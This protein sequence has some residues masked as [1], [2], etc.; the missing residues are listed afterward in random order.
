M[1][2]WAFW[3]QLPGPSSFLNRVVENVQDGCNLV[4]EWP[5]H[6]P[7]G[8]Q[9]GLQSHDKSWAGDRVRCEFQA[10]E[11][12]GCHP[13]EFLY[14]RIF[15]K[16]VSLPKITSQSLAGLESFQGRVI[17]L[18][19]M[20]AKTW[21]LWRPFLERYA[22]AATSVEAWRRTLFL[23]SL[24][25]K[26]CLKTPRKSVLLK[27]HR[28]DGYITPLDMQM[29][30]AYLIRNRTFRNLERKLMYAL[31]AR[32]SGWDPTLLDALADSSVSELCSPETLL[33]TFAARRGWNSGVSDNR[34]EAW[35]RGM[36][37]RFD[38]EDV[39]HGC[40]LDESRAENSVEYRLWHA[41]TEVLLPVVERERHR[42]VARRRG[43]LE[44]PYEAPA[45]IIDDV[46]DLEL[47]HILAQMNQYRDR[48]REPDRELVRM[49]RDIRNELAHFEPVS[50]NL[51]SQLLRRF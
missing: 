51:L 10:D 47:S 43:K 41:Q 26:T 32:L 4:L 50:A 38:E 11:F 31:L 21:E 2:L 46:R 39:L 45:G 14:E 24:S 9:K 49:L 1:S 13:E 30:A 35:A 27:S 29:Y 36:L 22:E 18:D 15:K 37:Q 5:E 42:I 20:N 28:W 6:G 7:S 23:V 25:G 17:V 40:L 8:W 48:F 16:E 3:W 34:E 12:N 33:N 44:V 19:G